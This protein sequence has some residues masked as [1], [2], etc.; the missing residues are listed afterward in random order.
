M[1]PPGCM[2]NPFPACLEYFVSRGA[3]GKAWT[4]YS[5][6]SYRDAFGWLGHVV[7]EC[8]ATH[9]LHPACSSPWES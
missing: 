2:P 6:W 1:P 9:H 8:M 7:L 3:E 4:F 5:Q